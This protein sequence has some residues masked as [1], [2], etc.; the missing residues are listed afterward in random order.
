MISKLFAPKNSTKAES[1]KKKIATKNLENQ[2]QNGTF[3]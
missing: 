3:N 1:I 2:N